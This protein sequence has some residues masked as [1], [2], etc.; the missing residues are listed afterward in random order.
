[1]TSLYCPLDAGE[2]SPAVHR[3]GRIHRHRGWRGDAEHDCDTFSDGGEA[4]VSAARLKAAFRELTVDAGSAPQ[5]GKPGLVLRP[6]T[7]SGDPSAIV[8]L[9][10]PSRRAGVDD[11]P[12]MKRFVI[13]AAAGTARIPRIV[14]IGTWAHRFTQLGANAA[15]LEYNQFLQ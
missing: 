15:A 4:D 13:C 8:I 3:R 12:E 10:W 14:R 5:S 6:C 2:A 7:D 9:R 1:M 11:G